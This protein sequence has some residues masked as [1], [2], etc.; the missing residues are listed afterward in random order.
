MIH[1]DS[2]AYAAWVTDEAGRLVPAVTTRWRVWQGFYP[3]TTA[4][5]VQLERVDA[6]ES[7]S[8]SSAGNKHTNAFK[9]Q[10]LSQGG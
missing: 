9:H 10:T 7:D 2:E 6:S 8:S 1:F 4:W 3:D 5:G